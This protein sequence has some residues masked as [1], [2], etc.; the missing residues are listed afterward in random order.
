MTEADDM[1]NWTYASESSIG[2]VARQQ[3]F[4]YQLALGHA[5]PAPGLRG[6]VQ[7]GTYSEENQRIFYRRW[8]QFMAGKDWSELMPESD[9]AEVIANAG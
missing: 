2:S 6:A 9:P 5:R 1:E 3:D 4:N 7:S 8:A